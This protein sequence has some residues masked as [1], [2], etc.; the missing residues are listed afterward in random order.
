ML[1]TGAVAR[2]IGEGQLDQLPTVF[3]SGRAHGMVSFTDALV[4]FVRAGSVD[5]REAFRKA[6]DRSGLVERLKNAGVDT[7]IV[8]RLA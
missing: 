2:V 3:A 5:I 6:P 7:T 1:A 4:D 8:E